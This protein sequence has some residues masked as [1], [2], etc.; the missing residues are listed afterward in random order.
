MTSP[1]DKIKGDIKPVNEASLFTNDARGRNF[2]INYYMWKWGLTLKEY[3]VP[4]KQVKPHLLQPDSYKA[5]L[6]CPEHDVFVEVEI[7]NS[8]KT[9]PFPSHWGPKTIWERKIKYAQE[10]K[11]VVYW[12]INNDLSQ[13]WWCRSADLTPD[14]LKPTGK[15]PNE[16]WYVIPPNKARD[17]NFKDYNEAQ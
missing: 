11:R 12:N 10:G 4:P 16:F 2:L 3:I 1:F 8:W 14:N 13:G 9:G 6:V 5:D 17:V 15:R 7:T